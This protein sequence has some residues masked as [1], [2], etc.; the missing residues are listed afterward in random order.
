MHK[1]AILNILVAGESSGN[2]AGTGRYSRKP[3]RSFLSTASNCTSAGFC[4]LIAETP[5][6]PVLNFTFKALSS[7]FCKFCF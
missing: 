4:E 7:I 1:I 2:H 6:S 3:S 5:V